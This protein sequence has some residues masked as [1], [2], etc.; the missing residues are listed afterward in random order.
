M[1]LGLPLPALTGALTGAL[2]LA[3]LAIAPAF[4]QDSEVNHIAVLTPEQPNDFGWNQQAA[5]AA[6][7]V[8]EALSID[9]T[10]AS[11][12]GYGDVRPTLRELAAEGADLLIAHASGYNTT[13]PEIAEET[14]VPVAIVDRPDLMQPG[15]VADYTL[16]GHEGAYLAGVL[17]TQMSRSATLGIVVSGEPPSW[18]SQSAAFAQGA[19][20]SDPDIELRYSV[21]GPAAYA[22]AAGARRVTDAVIAAG[23][24]VIFGQG[25]GSTFGIL[26]AVETNDAPDGG[27]I[28]FIDVIGD[29][30][31]ID[32][33]HLLSSV[34]WNLEPVYRAMIEDLGKGTFGTRGYSIRLEDESLYLLQSEHIPAEVWERVMEVREQIVAGEITVEPKFEAEAVR[35][36]MTAVSD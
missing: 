18:N 10:L 26:Q 11:G 4:A 19:R 32:G 34:V 6:R 33:G 17:A 3:G 30:S 5:K 1:K 14:G 36:L 21:I 15:L 25:N 24:D 13:A 28:W 20:A 2:F 16:S 29:K 22:D 12:L 8:G 7:A 31:S 23:A 27:K 9:V 35:A